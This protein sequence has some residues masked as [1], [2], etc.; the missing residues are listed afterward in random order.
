MYIFEG[1]YFIDLHLYKTFPSIYPMESQAEKEPVDRIIGSGFEPE[2][3]V[4][5]L[6]RWIIHVMVNEFF[7]FKFHN[8]IDY[9]LLILRW[10]LSKRLIFI[11]QIFIYFYSHFNF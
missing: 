3:S 10:K 2:S 7:F 11:D 9:R 8:L 6:Y 5:L 4:R 1:F